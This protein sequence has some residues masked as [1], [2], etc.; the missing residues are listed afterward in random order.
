VRAR[1]REVGRSHRIPASKEEL[2]VGKCV[3]EAEVLQ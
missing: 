3:I 1:L 2:T